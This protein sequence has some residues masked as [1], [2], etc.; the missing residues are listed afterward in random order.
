MDTVTL[1]PKLSRLKLS[2]ILET[3]ENRLKQA[4]ADKWSYSQFLDF[5]LSDEVE[6]RDHKQLVRRLAKSGLD[7]EKTLESFDFTFNPK[8]HEP[9]MREFG[10]CQFVEKNENLLLLGPSGVG[11]SH[12]AQAFGNEAVRRG[13]DVLCRRT[14]TLF[15]WIA[16]GEGDG[17][18]ERRLKTASSV[19]L[20]ILDDFGMKPLDE[21]QQSD[22]YELICERY[23][24]APTILTSN[25]DFNEWPMIFH[26]PLMGSAAMD[27][28]VHRAAKIL[29]EGKSYRVDEFIK[30][31]RK[32]T[33]EKTPQKRS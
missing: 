24:K 6:R 12:L 16:A 25:R 22:L 3:L 29:V 23:E 9:T 32:I 33:D 17:T 28:L 14:S 26:N 30:R 11:K 4:T 10:Q 7:P 27:R 2:G 13:Y 15:G 8:I 18:R 1:Q 19:P 5:L 20:L 21:S 31:T